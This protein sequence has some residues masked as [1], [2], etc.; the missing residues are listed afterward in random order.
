MIVQSIFT[1]C[2]SYIA[3]SFHEMSV[4]YQVFLAQMLECWHGIPEALCSSSG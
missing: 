4:V 3:A 2:L 1:Q